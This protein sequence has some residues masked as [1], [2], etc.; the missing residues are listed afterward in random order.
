MF[1]KNYGPVRQKSKQFENI[2]YYWYKHFKVYLF[3]YLLFVMVDRSNNIIIRLCIKMY[4]FLWSFFKFLIIVSSKHKQTNKQTNKRNRQTDFKHITVLY[5]SLW[6]KCSQYFC[7]Y[8][9]LKDTT[10]YKIINSNA[11]E[12]VFTMIQWR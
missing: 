8:M 4:V 6:K 9:K 11:W 5:L 12:T 3:V 10:K 7:L 1:L 2:I